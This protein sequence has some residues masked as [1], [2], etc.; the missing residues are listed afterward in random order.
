MKKHLKLPMLLAVLVLTSCNISWGGSTNSVNSNSTNSDNPSVVDS[1]TTSSLTPS[2]DTS[3]DTS[4]IPVSDGYEVVD[5]LYTTRENMENQS[6]NTLNTTG[7]QKM[8]IV[9]IK[10]SDGP[11]W[12]STMLSNLNTVFFGE[13]S[14]TSWR[15]VKTFFEESSY[16]KLTIT[17]EVMDVL[18]VNLT[19]AR[20]NQ[21][22][23]NNSYN[24]DPGDYIGELFY[25]K[26]SGQTNKLKE[27]DQD[28]DGFIDAVA[29]VYSNS[30]S[31]SNN[32]AYWAWCYS[33]SFD[34][35]INAPTVNNY[36]WASYE[37]MNDSYGS[38]NAPKG[39]EAHTYIHETGH[40]FGLDDYYCYDDDTPWDCAGDR[41]MQAYNIGDH[42][43]YS[44]L[45]LG[46]VNPYYVKDT[47]DITLRSSAKFGDAILIKDNW[48]KTIFDEY[49][50][51]E[52]Y[53]PEGLNEQ[54]S[55]YNY[56]SR[57]KMYAGSGLRIYHVDSRLVRDAQM[58]EMTGRV[59][60]G[61]F[62]STYIENNTIIG[63]SNS[64]SYSYLTTAQN[65]EKTRLL[66][67]IDS[68]NRNTLSAGLSTSS[69]S[70]IKIDASRTLWT[71]GQTFSATSA[72]FANG[73][74]TFND[75]TKVGYTV[76]V[77]ETKD[78]MITVHIAKTK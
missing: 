5:P 33:A 58:N 15:S 45:A 34:A 40:L 26:M 70:S 52:Y 35:S 50:L 12:T 60:N 71:E 19:V 31:S 66:H 55:K 59:S 67:L 3:D 68:G 23:N 75:G 11:S 61:G 32:S 73:N 2:I 53:T 37:F 1:S 77:K 72:Y 30:Y 18:N 54:D 24:Y 22:Y 56:D 10:F 78:G 39:L 76:N 21:N 25:N 7:E 43:I 44:K 8:L 38:V 63:P 16:G 74:D 28:K 20:F 65:P 13:S 47:C 64:V 69:S 14:S 4:M 49:I 9:P 42:N 57:N 29:F 62:S 41:D 48:N 6:W 36:M 46:W 51:I 17:G 27:Y